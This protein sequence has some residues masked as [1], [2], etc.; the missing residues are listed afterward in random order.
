[1]AACVNENRTTITVTTAKGR[2][3]VKK[4]KSSTSI[5]G[6]L[7]VSALTLASMS[8]TGV[9]AADQELSSAPDSPPGIHA[10]ASVEKS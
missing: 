6:I 9:R 4:A 7:A 2:C 5:A 8:T 10:G 3:L 1:M